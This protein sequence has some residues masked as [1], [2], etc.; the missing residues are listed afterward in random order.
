MLCGANQMTRLYMKRNTRQDWVKIFSSFVTL[1]EI[2]LSKTKVGIKRP[3][4]MVLSKQKR[5]QFDKL[6]KNDLVG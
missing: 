2:R 6:G 5:I 4:V 3:C 1:R